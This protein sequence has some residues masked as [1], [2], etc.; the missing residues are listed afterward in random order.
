MRQL[1]RILLLLFV[2]ALLFPSVASAADD[3]FVVVID[4]GHGGKD[5]GAVGRRGKE[6]NINLAVAVLAGKYIAEQYPDAKVIYTRKTDVFIGLNER[7]NIANKAKANLFISIHVNSSPSSIARGAEVYTFG[8]ARTKENLDIA[9]RENSVILLEDN[10]KEKYEGFDPN[11]SESYIIFEF[12]QNKFVEQ[13]IDFASMVRNQIKECVSW[14]DRGVKQAQYL[15]L[16]KSTMPRVLIELGFISNAGEEKVMMSENGRKQYAL[17]IANAFGRYKADWDKKNT[18]KKTAFNDVPKKPAVEKKPEPEDVFPA[19]MQLIE[20]PQTETERV[21]KVQILT[22]PKKLATDARILKGY[23]TDYY[24]ENNVYKYTY[25]SCAT[26]EEAMQL[27]K[28][29]ARDFK[30]A[31]VVIF[32]DGVRVKK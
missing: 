9:K 22:S 29:I 27:R 2:G 15:V 17:A 28:T 3:P 26:M 1:F 14:A 16:R 20:F 8:V 7:A 32:E 12:I 5:S 4:P 21:F 25:G 13:S 10:Y 18:G 11:S 23:Q 19:E 30:D 31:F 6:K 24:V